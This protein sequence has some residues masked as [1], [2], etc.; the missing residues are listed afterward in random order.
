MVVKNSLGAGKQQNNNI[1]YAA[2]LVATALMS[3][4]LSEENCARHRS[5]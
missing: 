2:A 1:H 3:C 5:F 4:R